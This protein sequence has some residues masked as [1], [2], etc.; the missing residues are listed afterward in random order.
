MS[1][2]GWKGSWAS[3]AQKWI[4]NM[5]PWFLGPVLVNCWLMTEDLDRMILVGQGG[6]GTELHEVVVLSV[7]GKCKQVSRELRPFLIPKLGG[8][9]EVGDKGIG[10][11]GRVKGF[12]R[13]ILRK[14][15]LSGRYILQRLLACF[16]KK[17]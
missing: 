15:P 9:H 11:C 14:P 17:T 8:L 10:V 4:D 1:K 7:W 12:R 5:S 3:H 6:L 2:N 16:D 13:S